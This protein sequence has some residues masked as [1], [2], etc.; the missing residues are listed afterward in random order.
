MGA[1][2]MQVISFAQSS[3]N[4]NSLARMVQGFSMSPAD[5]TRIQWLEL[6]LRGWVQELQLARQGSSKQHAGSDD[7]GGPVFG[8]TKFQ[9]DFLTRPSIL[10]DIGLD[11]GK[12]KFPER[13]K[14]TDELFICAYPHF[15]VQG[16]ALGELCSLGKHVYEV[17]ANAHF[18][19]LDQ[20]KPVFNLLN[21]FLT[22]SV[23]FEGW[24]QM[25]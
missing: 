6:T 4:F 25:L 11:F 5:W 9:L 15:N 21:L 13:V 23:H 24:S 20:V 22:S 16:E 19:L 12:V 14:P 17:H 10:G 18:I 3:L 8:S 7:D 2:K 1:Q